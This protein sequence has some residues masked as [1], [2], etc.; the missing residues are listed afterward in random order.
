MAHPA[1]DQ[2]FPA[3]RCHETHPVRFGVPSRTLEVRELTDVVDFHVFRGA[4]RLTGSGQEPLEEFR[5]SQTLA[6]KEAIFNGCRQSR[7]EGYPAEASDQRFPTF[8]R[9]PYFQASAWAVRSQYLRRQA[10]GHFG[11]R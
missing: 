2:R 8:A 10:F 3:S 7:P 5:T 4:T 1:Q 11:N 6:S 9:H